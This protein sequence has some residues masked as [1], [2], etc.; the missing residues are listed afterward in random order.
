[1]SKLF[2]TYLMNIHS[3]DPDSLASVFENEPMRIRYFKSE[4]VFELTVLDFYGYLA[5]RDNPFF[6]KV[7]IAGAD[8]VRMLKIDNYSDDEKNE[9]YYHRLLGNSGGGTGLE[10][11]ELDDDVF[12]GISILQYFFHISNALL[13]RVKK[14][15]HLYHLYRVPSPYVEIP[16]RMLHSKGGRPLGAISEVIPQNIE[17]A[18]AIISHCVECDR[19]IEYMDLSKDLVRMR[20]RTDLGE[21]LTMTGAK[22]K[23]YIL[24]Y[25][26][27]VRNGFI[28][29][30]KNYEETLLIKNNKYKLFDK[31]TF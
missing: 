29:R 5:D 19:Y 23:F 16:K 24:R 3:V 18:E 14:Q 20:T 15:Y 11:G 17:N 7:K 1:M 31:L 4:D 25:K 6:F 22:W 27:K 30:D 21:P 8:L 2:A 10:Q 9:L 13:S 12:W 26:Y 28:Q